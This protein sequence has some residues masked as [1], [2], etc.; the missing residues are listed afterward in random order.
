MALFDD[1]KLA[2]RVSGGTTAYDAEIQGTIAAALSSLA[3]AG[4]RPDLLDESALSGDSASEAP[5]ALVKQAV[6]FYAK[7]HFGY[8]N[9][10]R[11]QF[12]DCYDRTVTA[13]ELCSMSNVECWRTDIADC[14]VADIAAQAYTGRPVRP[15]PAV[16]L[17]GS[18]L[19]H[20]RDFTLAYADNVEA[21][22]AKVYVTGTGAYAGTV[23]KSF[24]I[25]AA[26]E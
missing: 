1:V 20:G 3:M 14:E 17:D 16:S 19:A 23:A 22:T 10:E 15:V 11:M 7:A 13:L 12:M 25:E 8:D 9:S 2:L 21:G 24:E 5:A 26:G 18:A 6:V 4:V